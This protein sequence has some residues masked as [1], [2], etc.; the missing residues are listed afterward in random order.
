[1]SAI[2]MG[3]VGLGNIGAYHAEYLSKG[4]VARADLAAVCDGVPQRLEDWSQLAT[5][6]DSDALFRSGL[7][8]TVIIAT[9]SFT[10][11]DLAVA[12]LEQGLHVLVEKPMAL[13][14]A[15]CERMLA[16]AS[17]AQRLLAVMHNNRALE[18]Y[19]K[20]RS[21][22]QGGELGTLQRLMWVVTDWFRPQAYYA[23]GGWRATWRGEGGGVLMNQAIH[24]VDLLQW[25]AGLP[26]RVSAHCGIGRHHTIQVEDEVTAY[27]EY[28]NGATGLFVASTGESPGVNRLEIVGSRATLTLEDG[29]ISL[30]RNETDAREYARTTEDVFGRPDVWRIQVPTSDQG[31]GH[32][33]ITQNLVDAI[34]GDA[35]LLSPGS[36]AAGA[37]H[38]ANAMLYSHFQGRPIDLPLDGAAYEQHLAHLIATSDDPRVVQERSPQNIRQSFVA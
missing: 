5:F 17:S 9:P 25:I 35:P 7:I 18:T 14:I 3:L 20:V 30:L 2:R 10:H 24:Q 28:P 23:S 4:Q 22:L 31:T 13:Q 27:L 26:C 16:A 33:A 38:L 32:V 36:G 15:E 1:M 19:A 29:Q 8:D 6:A 11:H 37:I 12:A 21:L 34:L